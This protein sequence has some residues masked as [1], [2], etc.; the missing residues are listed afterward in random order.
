MFFFLK[1]KKLLKN[2]WDVRKAFLRKHLLEEAMAGP[3]S[4]LQIEKDGLA[5]MKS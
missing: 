1:K 4:F 5:L 3:W 2:I